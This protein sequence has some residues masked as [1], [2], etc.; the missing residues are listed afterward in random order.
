MDSTDI[1][2]CGIPGKGAPVFS[3]II[4]VWNRQATIRR[5]LDSVLVQD[6]A[7]FEIVAVD[8]G[9]EDESVATMETYKDARLRIVRHGA[10]RGMCASRNTGTAAARGQ[11]IVSLDSDD[12]LE[13]GALGYL[14]EMARKAPADVGVIGGFARRDTGEL[15][16]PALPPEAPFGF[17]EYLEWN[18]RGGGD[19]LPCRR[20]E[21]FQT[22]QWPTDRSLAYTFHMRLAKAWRMWIAREVLQR[23]YTD[24]GNRMS[25][26]APKPSGESKRRA[27]PDLAADA[28]E[29]LAAFGPEL[30]KHAPF[31]YWCLLEGAALWNLVAGRRWRGT[32]YALRAYVRRPLAIHLLG[33]I[34]VG[35]LGPRAFLAAM[36]WGWARRIHR[37]IRHA[38]VPSAG[39]TGTAGGCEN[40]AVGTGVATQGGKTRASP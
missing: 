32:K 2:P 27:A 38:C 36:R 6:F 3:V 25:K 19:Y 18:N 4:P 5:C 23:I 14:W 15:A 11:W 1:E 20:Q 39:K 16:C 21:V 31:Y 8:D 7:D 30:R 24:S 40:R 26:E 29:A 37:T 13:P 33:I 12:A 10:N 35:A 28:E 22:I 34:V 9:S 17:V